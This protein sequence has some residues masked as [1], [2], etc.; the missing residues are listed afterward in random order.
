MWAGRASLLLWSALCWGMG[1]P[2]AVDTVDTALLMG[3]LQLS[4]TEPEWFA[5][6]PNARSSLVCMLVS[7][8]S[9]GRKSIVVDDIAVPENL[10]TATAS[11]NMTIYTSGVNVSETDPVDEVLSH[12]QGATMGRATEIVNDCLDER[13]GGGVYKASMQEIWTTGVQRGGNA[14]VED[15]TWSSRPVSSGADP[16]SRHSSLAA[17]VPAAWAA[18]ASCGGRL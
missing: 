12:L 8:T 1:R 6:D 13:S 18:W 10:G 7:L 15:M 4:V 16:T 9:L 17:L 5:K 14:S 2:S 3:G 11:F